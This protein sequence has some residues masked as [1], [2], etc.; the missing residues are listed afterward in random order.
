M[1][2]PRDTE[3]T[4]RFVEVSRGMWCQAKRMP[5]PR[6]KSTPSTPSPKPTMRALT[7]GP[8][9]NKKLKPSQPVVDNP[10]K[11]ETI[12][13][14]V[15]DPERHVDD[16]KCADDID[17]KVK[18]DRQEQNE[19]VDTIQADHDEKVEKGTWVP[20]TPPKGPRLVTSRILKKGRGR[21][22]EHEPLSY[23]DVEREPD[24]EPDESDQDDDHVSY[25]D[26]L[27]NERVAEG[28]P[29][30]SLTTDEVWR[31][32]QDSDDEYY[33]DEQPTFD[34][35]G[36]Q[37]TFDGDGI[38]PIVEDDDPNFD[39][40]IPSFDGPHVE[41]DQSD[42]MVD[43]KK[44]EKKKDKK[45]KKDKQAR[46]HKKKKSVSKDEIPDEIPVVQSL[47][48]EADHHIVDNPADDDDDL[49]LSQLIQQS[50]RRRTTTSP[51]STRMQR[52]REGR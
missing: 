29:A 51:W 3:P 18:V 32:L 44:K 14:V 23:C 1:E 42:P 30:A 20:T 28:S 24:S 9:I 27:D 47:A 37:P 26:E 33:F 36:N 11:V 19:Q 10:D 40:H 50:K 6:A 38:L 15:D 21:D 41:D 5:R 43:K 34:G 35:D 12:Q 8:D 45:D 25:D 46:K 39:G 2:V 16:E 49:P 13:P 52:Q 7:D 22:F 48:I 4:V 31:L 17:D